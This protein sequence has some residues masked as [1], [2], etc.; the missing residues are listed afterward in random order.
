[1]RINTARLAS[2]GR[3]PPV[4][5]TSCLCRRRFLVA[6]AGQRRDPARKLPES[7]ECRFTFVKKL[8]N[9]LLPALAKFGVKNASTTLN[10]EADYGIVC[11]VNLPPSSGQF[12]VN[13]I[14]QVSHTSRLSQYPLNPEFGIP[15][16]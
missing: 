7:G 11:Q 12:R 8:C 14:K 6:R 1:M 4:S 16:D 5:T 10:F 2:R 13:E 9:S 15:G 3:Q